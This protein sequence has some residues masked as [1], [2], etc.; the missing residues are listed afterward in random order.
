M[1]TTREALRRVLLVSCVGSIGAIGQASAQTPSVEEMWEIIQQQQTTIEALQA[2]INDTDQKVEAAGEMIE[3]AASN[4]G[5]DRLHW[6]GYGE[7]HY[8]AG[9]TQQI[10]VH[11]F[12]LFT[13]Y[14]FND[15]L[16]LQTEFELEHALAG[17]GQPG[18][19]EL[20]QAFIEWD[21]TLGK[22][23]IAGVH[24]IP[25]GLLNETHEPPTFFGVER[26]RIHSE[27][28]PSTWWEAGVGTKG[29]LGD[30]VGY[31]FYVHS[32]LET[33]VTG[34]NAFRIRSGR[35]KVAEA[36]ANQPA[37]TGRIRWN[38]MP[39]V[40]VNAAVQ[41]QSDLTQGQAETSTDLDHDTSA[42]LYNVNADILISGWGLRAMYAQWDLD[43]GTAGVGPVAFGRDEQWGYLIEPSYRFSVPGANGQGTL[44][45]FARHTKFDSK[46][47]DNTDS[48]EQSFTIGAN[49][50]IH[51]NVVFKMDYDQ[52]STQE[53]TGADRL[54]V[55]MG[56]Q[57]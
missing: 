15:K 19:V 33:P 30:G 40:N 32:G 55:G 2:Q 9:D 39:G 4:G 47:S 46:A 27:I 10:D 49:Y 14:D 44:G 1:R 6:G 16:R 23:L 31:D 7:I 43:A 48:E 54:N 5:D 52:V 8:N 37:V 45:V 22:S 13:E 21:V 17:D 51:P 28:I 38:G 29:E 57:F 36:V 53:S 12:V 50:W 25:V 3:E 41:Y 42:W 35:Q 34:S 56:W 24:L 20:E 18:E 11:R 26:D